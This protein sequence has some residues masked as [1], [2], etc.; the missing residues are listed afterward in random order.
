MTSLRQN[1]LRATT[2]VILLAISLNFSQAL[3]ENTEVTLTRGANSSHLETQLSQDEYR[4][5]AYEDTYYESVPYEAIEEY[6][7]DVPYQD[8][9]YYEVDVPYQA[10]ESYMERETYYENE[11]RCERV[12]VR[13]RV[14]RD[15]ER[16]VNEQVRHCTKRQVC[17][18][19]PRGKIC[20][21][22]NDCTTKTERK[23]HSR[24][25][26]E[27]H[28]T[29]E[30]QCRTVRVPHTR[31]VKKSR[32]VTRY[33]KETKSRTVT[34]YKKETR[35]RTVTRYRDEERC[36]VTKYREVFDH[37]WVLNVEIKFPENA[38]LYDTETEKV[39]VYLAGDE[40][41]PEAS[42]NIDSSIYRYK[43]K[44]QSLQGDTYRIQLELNPHLGENEL[45]QHTIS[46][47]GIN[48]ISR[49]SAIIS[50]SEQAYLPR[51]MS[52]YEVQLIEQESGENVFSKELIANKKGLVE[53]EVDKQLDIKKS[54]LL[55]LNVIREGVVVDKESVSFQKETI[56]DFSPLNDSD[57]DRSS[58]S[59]ISAKRTDKI[60]SIK[61]KDKGLHAKITSEYIFTITD[62]LS[63]EILSTEKAN[64][65]DLSQDNEGNLVYSVNSKP[66]EIKNVT[67][68]LAVHRKSLFLNKDIEFSY[69]GDLLFEI[70]PTPYKD[71]TLLQKIVVK[72]SRLEAK[73]SFKDLS[74]VLSYVDTEYK[75]K[76]TRKGSFSKRKTLVSYT[77]KRSELIGNKEF[78]SLSL[79]NDLKG[80]RKYIKKYAK[81]NKKL[82]VSI[83]VKR[84]D[85]RVSKI[86]IANFTKSVKLKVK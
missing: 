8:I 38:E 11:E 48:F 32:T 66:F 5:E 49:S 77:V 15:V 82:T 46:N 78:I 39:N 65:L 31:M 84:L 76:I 19:T 74:K 26:C 18:D 23:C 27:D 44:E 73:L 67:W 58:I 63:K 29:Y 36:C 22:V 83:Q 62:S 57:H 60:L 28:T 68:S 71:Q 24:P 54:Y 14:C 1:F 10:R 72:G 7:V 85:I 4:T 50:F 35:T 56:Y 30:R 33:R 20:R 25:V 53:I 55:K 59:N 69:N 6:E 37:Q 81:S 41:N 61:F 45:G 70:D 12:P 64:P 16:C 47:F 9:E 2:S 79:L 3:A 42:I 43:I 52:A 86:E 80:S 51:V 21:P 34:R 13:N 17:K 40:A 75:I